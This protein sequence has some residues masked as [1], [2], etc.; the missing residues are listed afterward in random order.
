[1]TKVSKI[2]F[3]AKV[4]SATFSNTDRCLQPVSEKS[5]FSICS[6]TKDT[7]SFAFKRQIDQ[8]SRRPGT[9]SLSAKLK[10]D[11]RRRLQTQ[12]LHTLLSESPWRDFFCFHIVITICATTCHF[13]LCRW[14][15]GFENWNEGLFD[16]KKNTKSTTGNYKAP[17]GC[18]DRAGRG[19]SHLSNYRTS[20]SAL[21][22]PLYQAS[23]ALLS[24]G[25]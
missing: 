2:T 4:I 6:I 18:A 13:Q 19:R 16:E 8:W 10:L 20:R 23:A 7:D 5:A 21:S 9:E 3:Y 17:T 11:I 24:A 22:V 14:K 1:M 12:G 15:Q 25:S